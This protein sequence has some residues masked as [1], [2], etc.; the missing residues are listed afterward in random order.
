MHFK[1]HRL[2]HL[3]VE[4]CLCFTLAMQRRVWLSVE[5]AQV[6][7]SRISDVMHMLL[8]LRGKVRLPALAC[9]LPLSAL[10]RN[11]QR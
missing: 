8:H 10:L 3:A 5:Q 6:S 9:C 11:H 1:P 2:Q 4:R 7:A